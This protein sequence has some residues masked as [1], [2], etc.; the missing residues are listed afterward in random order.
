MEK[1]SPK[2]LLEKAAKT[3][4]GKYLAQVKTAFIFK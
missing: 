3:R 1:L 2:K 4:M